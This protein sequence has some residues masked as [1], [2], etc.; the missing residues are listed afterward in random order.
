MNIQVV[1]QATRPGTSKADARAAAHTAVAPLSRTVV[2][3]TAEP[4]GVGEIDWLT[5]PGQV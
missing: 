5:D 3:V 1:R 4:G 2:S